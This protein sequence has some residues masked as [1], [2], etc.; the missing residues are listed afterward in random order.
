MTIGHKLFGSY[1]ALALLAMGVGLYML[2]VTQRIASSLIHN[3]RHF[4]E[5][6]TGATEV[7][8]Y[9]K[10]AEGH[11]LIFLTLSDAKDRDKFH[12][13][14]KVL[15]EQVQLLD[16]AVAIPEARLILDR[17]RRKATEVLPVG[18]ALLT[19]YDREVAAS[20]RFDFRAHGDAIRGF[21]ELTS[22][23]R[24]LAEELTVFETKLD[25][26]TQADAIV[27]ASGL[28]RSALLMLFLGVSVLLV[29]GY[30]ILRNISGPIVR[31]TTAITHIEQ[32]APGP[33]IPL[34][35]TSRDEIGSLTIS[36][37]RLLEMRQRSDNR[38]RLLFNSLN[39]TVLVYPLTP[40]GTP[41]RYI[42]VNDAACRRTGY[43]RDELLQRSPVE[44]NSPE[45][46]NRMLANVALLL[47]QTSVI[48]DAEHVTKGGTRIPVEISAHVF[49]LGGQPTVLS[50][51]RDV[52]ERKLLEAQFREAQKMEVVGQ[53]AGGIAHD[54]NNLL[55]AMMMSLA[56]ARMS[57]ITPAT[58]ATLDDLEALAH[59]AA[60]LTGQLL[61]F[62]RKKAMRPETLDLNAALT[63]VLKM[64]RSLVGEH[65]RLDFVKAFP[66]IWIDADAGMLDQV[67]MN[68]CVNARDAM[69]GGGTLTVKAT[70]AEIESAGTLSKVNAR[71]G[72]FACIQISDVGCGMSA[73]VLSHL[74][75]PFFTTKGIGKGTGLGLATVHGIVLQHQGWVEVESVLGAGT[76]FRVYLPLTTKNGIV[77]PGSAGAGLSGGRETILLVEDD[78]A[79]RRG[80][81]SVLQ[82]L[83]YD[84]IVA[85]NGPE[86]LHLWR[87]HS[88][89]IDLL[90]TDM[91]MPGGI[92]GLE[93][94]EKLRQKNAALKIIIMS[95]Y[96]TE[97]VSEEE[98]RSRNITI[99]AKPFETAV[100]AA[101]IRQSLG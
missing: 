5:V 78:E 43:T 32:G 77:S 31:L 29:A 99:V 91:V 4:Q 19:A 90:V 68:L 37:N 1:F 2:S 84:L 97:A 82:G 15:D 69:P 8:N 9:A 62:A 6:I 13:R 44:L 47:K 22:L 12:Q 36:F 54:F 38:F 94:G 89:T 61:L 60:R 64:L 87:Q 18:D 92:T 79:V 42:E 27:S 65:I 30:F 26:R 96:S 41:G 76:T 57:P 56:L 24:S 7:V 23:V 50:I 59:R 14:C 17:L 25:A 100:L 45:T 70:V 74:F 16:H 86:A 85:T 55:T 10:R 53:L 66:A 34:P 75:E 71:P 98:L 80:C 49:E 88:G 21:Q 52:S 39:D 35:V 46:T 20:G 73:E 101:A 83:G 11:L 63:S 95:G 93:L 72:R 81:T 58:E 40:D 3:E 48:A 67:I 33:F 51:A 28:Q